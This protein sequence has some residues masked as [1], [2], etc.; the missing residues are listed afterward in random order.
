MF[1]IAFSKYPTHNR[2]IQY[3]PYE[4]CIMSAITALDLR[5]IAPAQCHA[6]VCE[7]FQS[8]PV[9]EHFEL[10]LGHAPEPLQ[11]Q[12]EALWPN[13]LNWTVVEAGASQWCVRITRQ[14]AGKTCC[15]C[16]CG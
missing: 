8:L 1:D 3:S 13:Q 2:S 4:V 6:M 16:C 12:L 15:G 11:L 5:K 10:V 7:R 9:G 14:P